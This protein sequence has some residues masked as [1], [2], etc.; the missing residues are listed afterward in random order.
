MSKQQQ[1]QC[2]IHRLENMI[3][4]KLGNKGET[5]KPHRVQ[6]TISLTFICVQ[7]Y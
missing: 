2:D 4:G 6:V 7:M 3:F 5:E 1:E